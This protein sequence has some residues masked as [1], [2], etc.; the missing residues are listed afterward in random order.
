MYS[1][2]GIHTYIRQLVIVGIICML[3]ACGQG[4]TNDMQT[5]PGPGRTESQSQSNAQAVPLRIMRLP[6]DITQMPANWGAFNLDDWPVNRFHPIHLFGA[7]Y[8]H[9]GK[10]EATLMFDFLPVGGNVVAPFDGQIREVRDQAESCDTEMYLLPSRDN[11]DP[12]HPSVSLD[13][14]IPLDAFRTPGATF[15]AGDVIATLG[16][17][18]CKDDFARFELMIL[19]QT[20]QGLKAECPMRLLDDSI[21]PTVNAQVADVMQAWNALKPHIPYS[22][23]DLK[24]GICSMPYTQ[25]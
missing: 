16:K 14:V 18:E 13:H 4:A 17:W 8:D 1:F 23:D 3:V 20:D 25:P 21:A 24:N 19:A 15:K 6:Y 11:E 7:D 22:P 5:T 12:A 10:L 2:H 9:N